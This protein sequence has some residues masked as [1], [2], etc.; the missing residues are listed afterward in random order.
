MAEPDPTPLNMHMVLCVMLMA[1]ERSKTSP[2]LDCPHPLLYVGFL[3]SPWKDPRLGGSNT[4]GVGTCGA[5]TGKSP[6]PPR[7]QRPLV[8]HAGDS[9]LVLKYRVT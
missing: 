5:F 8:H 7:L 3:P 6:A 4:L 9:M 1:S 2:S